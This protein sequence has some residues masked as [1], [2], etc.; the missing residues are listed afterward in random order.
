MADRSVQI[1]RIKELTSLLSK[2]SRAYYRDAS[3]IMSDREYDKLYDE[4][5]RLEKETGVRLTGSPT[6]R[7]GDETLSELPKERHEKP[8][9][10][11]D[12][13]KNPE[14]VKAFLIKGAK[15]GD[16]PASCS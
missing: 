4:L 1:N 2:A 6:A 7:V 12:K 10:S 13:T 8:M 15:D 5:E 11:L 3:E 14:D 9:L 16:A